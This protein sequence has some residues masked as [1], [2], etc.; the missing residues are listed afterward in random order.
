MIPALLLG[1]FQYLNNDYLCQINY[2]NVRSILVNGT[3]AYGIPM[4]ITIGC[5]IYTWKKMQRENNHLFHTMTRI[6]QM[7]ARRD[8]IV[9]FQICLLIGLLMIIIIT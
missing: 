5:C 3:L 7:I 9:L 8:L 2:V 6:Q 4:Y 1:D